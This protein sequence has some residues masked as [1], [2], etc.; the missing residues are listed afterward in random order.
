MTALAFGCHAAGPGVLHCAAT[1]VWLREH[2]EG[3]TDTWTEVR[4]V[5]THSMD[6]IT[7]KARPSLGTY[8]G[9]RERNQSNRRQDSR[10]KVI[11]ISWPRHVTGFT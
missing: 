5:R 11:T 6:K 8:W 1:V 4:V 2:Q 9:V 10:P 7:M 3:M